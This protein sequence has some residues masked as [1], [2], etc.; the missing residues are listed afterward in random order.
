MDRR[1]HRLSIHKILAIPVEEIQ[2]YKDAFDMFDKEGRGYISID[3][4]QRVL[5]NFGFELD[6]EKIKR[7]V[8]HLDQD[9][10]GDID[11]EELITIMK[12]RIVYEEDDDE[13]IIR[14]FK[15]FDKDKK[16]Y[17]TCEEFKYILKVYCQGFTDKQI[18]DIFNASDLNKDG[19]LDYKEYIQFWKKN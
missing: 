10:S 5:K 14:A 15:E 7:M 19:K 3:Q 2:Q 18:E 6:K 11:F 1:K 13:M 12:T 17:I 4:F 8:S 16:G 9:K